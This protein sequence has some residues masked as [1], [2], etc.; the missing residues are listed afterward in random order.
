[1]RGIFS[2][3][4]AAYFQPDCFDRRDH[5][6]AFSGLPSIGLKAIALTALAFRLNNRRISLALMTAICVI[7]A[8]RTWIR[9]PD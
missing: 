5:G 3:N 1:M 2:T 4:V 7:F 6:G 9:N 8:A